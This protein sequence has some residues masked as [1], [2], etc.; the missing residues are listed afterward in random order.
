MNADG[1][2]SF[3]LPSGKTCTIYKGKG[4]HA[5]QAMK[6]CDGKTEN[7]LPALMSQLI[8]IDGNGVVME[9]FDEMDM[10]D[11]MAIQGE[12]ADQNFTSPQGT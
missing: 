1:S 5:I 7:Y 10:Q 8:E 2:K 9:D 6:I 3:T 4:K 12:F 11:F